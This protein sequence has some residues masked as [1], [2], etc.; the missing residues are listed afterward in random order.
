MRKTINLPL[1][2]VLSCLLLAACAIKAPQGK[3]PAPLKIG[4]SVALVNITPEKL[5]YAKSVGIDY[6]ETSFQAYIDKDLNLKKSEAEIT[7]EVQKVK[8]TADKAG[9]RFWSVHMPYNQKIDLSLTDETERQKVVG[10]H[11]KV[12]A[13]CQILEPQVILFHPSYYLTPGE[14]EQRKKQLITSSLELLPAVKAI[15]A[16][17]VIENML[18]P[19]LMADAKR[20]R[21]LCRSVEETLEIMNR[22]PKDIYSAVDMNHIK[23]P[24]LLIRALGGRVK[25]IHAA[26]GHGEKEN[27]Y[28]PCS[29]QG[30]NNWSAILAALEEAGYRGPFLFESAYKDE[31]ELKECYLSLY[32]AYLAQRQQIK[33]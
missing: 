21:P 2:V 30:S 11:K 28:F 25:S 4:Y 8:A 32:S 26:D 33:Q 14:R 3:T 22:L 5:A 15:N 31:K 13:F 24:E 10:L 20:E 17:M 1:L 9:I 7:E 16:T 23:H 29:G 27:H 19:E 6:L 18:G 12:L